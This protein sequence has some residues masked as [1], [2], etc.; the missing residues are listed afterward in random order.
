MRKRELKKKI[1]QGFS[2]LAPDMVETALEEAGQ[3]VLAHTAREP[4]Q[5]RQ[6]EPGMRRNAFQGRF[7]KR[8]LSAC[9]G[10]AVVCLCFFGLIQQQQ[11]A[12]AIVLDINPSI[13]VEVNG[14]YQVKRLSG[15]NEDGK[16]IVEK[17]EW[18]KDESLQDLLDVLIQDTVQKSYLDENGGIL[19]SLFTA[20][21][22]T[23]K[24][25]ECEVETRID[26]KLVELEIPSVTVAFQ[27]IKDSPAK[28]GRKLLEKKLVESYGLDKKQAAQMTVAEL[29][30]YCEEN[31]SVDL[32]VSKRHAKE[33]QSQKGNASHKTKGAAEKETGVSPEGQSR[34]SAVSPEKESGTE[35]S[36]EE[37]QSTKPAASSKETQSETEAT[38]K[39]EDETSKDAEKSKVTNDGQ[40]DTGTSENDNSDKNE[41]NDSEQKHSNHKDD[42]VN[43]TD[44][45]KSKTK[46]SEET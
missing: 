14:D 19:V 24:D 40:K 26:E 20:D 21:T 18:Q 22:D 37:T 16:S 43:K 15:L 34:A 3:Q 33:R 10:F 1:E 13:Q 23:F 31:T 9:V 28:E 35:K 8:T 44:Q 4:F 39:G 45:N 25:L 42:N 46:I 27:Q 7:R 38:H 17:L 2:E 30:E 11:D 41:D 29:I 5:P 12:V 36:S 6:T 32:E